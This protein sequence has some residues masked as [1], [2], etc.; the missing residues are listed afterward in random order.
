MRR[1]VVVLVLD[2]LLCSVVGCG[3][4]VVWFGLVCVCVVRRGVVC[5]GDGN[6]TAAYHGVTGE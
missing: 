5:W 1:G 3:D 2:G 4:G 6:L